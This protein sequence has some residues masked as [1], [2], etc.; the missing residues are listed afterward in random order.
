MRTQAGQRTK[1]PWCEQHDGL[2]MVLL[3]KLGFL[4]IAGHLKTIHFDTFSF[5]VNKSGLSLVP[6]SGEQ[7][8]S[9]DIIS[10]LFLQPVACLCMSA[11][12]KKVFR[13][14]M[15]EGQA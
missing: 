15:I 4:V 10:F 6:A 8:A 7:E 13:L 5:P 1:T 12:S 11:Y 2:L 14:G 3:G 9:S